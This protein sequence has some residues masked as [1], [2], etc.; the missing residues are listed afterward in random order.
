M[1]LWGGAQSHPI[2]VGRRGRGSQVW[3]S[4][5]GPGVGDWRHRLEAE[6]EGAGASGEHVHSG[7]RAEEKEGKTRQRLTRG[8]E[9]GDSRRLCSGN[10]KGGSR[11][12]YVCP[13]GPGL[14]S[15]CPPREALGPR[16]QAHPIPLRGPVSAT[17]TIPALSGPGSGMAG[18][19]ISQTRKPEAP[20][21]EL[22]KPVPL[23]TGSR[24]TETRSVHC[25]RCSQR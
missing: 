17:H 9:T 25:E 4:C 20:M 15:S 16:W 19:S 18:G 7:Y 10:R 13:G 11:R 12:Q 1:E 21:R 6:R 22:L 23:L 24:R 3:D 5:D 2:C 14:G 8:P